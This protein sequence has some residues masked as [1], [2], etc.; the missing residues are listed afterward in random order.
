MK[1]L[2]F[3]DKF[4]LLAACEKFGGENYLTET[5]AWILKNNQIL[6]TS[7]IRELFDVQI[8]DRSFNILTQKY[9]RTDS[10]TGYIDL[11]I[12]TSEYC[13]IYEHKINHSFEEAQIL[14]YIEWAKSKGYPT[15]KIMSATVS[16][17]FI[18]HEE[19]VKDSKNIIV[20]YLWHEIFKF[21]DKKIETE[22]FTETEK[23]V[24]RCFQNLLIKNELTWEETEVSME[25]LKNYYAAL[26]VNRSLRDMFTHI[27]EQYD[28]KNVYELFPRSG[29]KKRPPK[30]PMERWGR[31]GIDLDREI[32]WT[33]SIF[34]GVLTDTK[35]HKVHPSSPELGPDFCLI[36]D[37]DKNRFGDFD[38]SNEYIN[39]KSDMQKWVNENGDGWKFYDHLKEATGSP[40]LWHPLYIRKPLYKILE[41]SVTPE[42][43]RKKIEVAMTLL[44]N[45]I[46][47]KSSFLKMKKSFSEN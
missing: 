30:T 21:L 43:Q 44:L 31:I 15:E 37:I 27:K 32:G 11:V 22:K 29:G 47:N 38:L 14:K 17:Y 7:Y 40:N 33:P 26:E 1:T 13:F 24:L 35:D 34:I 9:A 6:L 2:N 45:A 3:E 18:N 41:D 28:W 10:N 25:G 8:T 39:L 20:N 42:E 36:I 23:F 5:W 46:L 4:G 16:G 19:T 12:T